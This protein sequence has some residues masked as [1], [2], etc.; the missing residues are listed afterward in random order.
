MPFLVV[1]RNEAPPF[2]VEHLIEV[3]G[4]VAYFRV[5]NS[6]NQHTALP[7]KDRLKSSNDITS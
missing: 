3:A 4:W 6:V 7:I 1:P 2:V 5:G